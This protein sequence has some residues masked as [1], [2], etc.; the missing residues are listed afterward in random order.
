MNDFF[1]E[2]EEFV[3]KNAMAIHNILNNKGYET[4]FVGG[5][6]RDYCIGKLNNDKCSIKDWDITT[7]ARYNDLKDIF[8]KLLRVNENGKVVSKKGKV[9]L[10][11]PDIETTAVFINKSMF[12]VTP[13]N[14]K[15]DGN[16]SFTNNLLEDL[17]TRDFTI[18]TIAYSPKRGAISNFKNTDGI[19]I[20]A[21]NDIDKKIIKT[22]SE[23][24]LYI[25]ENRFTIVRALLFANKLNF[26]IEHDTLE[27]IREH[28]FEVNYINKGKLSKSFERLILSKPTDKLEYIIYTG[29][30]EAL[31]LDFNKNLGKEFVNCLYKLSLK[32]DIDCYL[33]RLKFI[34][35]SFS[36]KELLVELYKEFGVNK[37]IISSVC[38]N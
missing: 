14:I 28:I 27:A 17:S 32:G 30:L 7:T 12:E 38:E 11:I 16:V 9:E 29:L 22:V 8:N 19:Y 6:L 34:Y 26:E 21:V 2:C 31:V 36:N 37:N 5:A 25:K 3:P 18:N 20:D 4:Y 24:N 23:P 15:K 10:L 35:D 1:K 33:A 13:M